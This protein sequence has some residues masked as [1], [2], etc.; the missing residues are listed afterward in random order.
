[1]SAPFLEGTTP[2]VSD[3]YIVSMLAGAN[4]TIGTLVELTSDWTVQATAG[5]NSLK[6]VGLTFDNAVAGRRVGIVCRG[7][8]RATASG[9]ITAG[10]QLASAAG[11]TVATDNSSKNSSIIG[12]ALSSVTTGQT[13]YVLLW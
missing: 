13:V 10:D 3:R 8:C 4:L 7:I 12:I 5:S 11:G 1:M 6:V 9:T 2:L